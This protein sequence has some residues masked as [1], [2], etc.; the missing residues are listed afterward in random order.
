MLLEHVCAM[1]IRITK[2]HLDG[3]IRH[4]VWLKNRTS[5][6][7]LNG[8]TPY[9]I[10]HGKPPSL[11]GLLEWGTQAHVL[12]QDVRKLSARSEEGCWVGYSGESQ[13]H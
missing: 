5:T 7:A 8:K 13:G 3:S 9:E 1:L 4:A 10:L 12:N 2:F 11:A 6:H